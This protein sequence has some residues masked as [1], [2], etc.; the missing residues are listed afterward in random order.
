M[1][2]GRRLACEV[3]I[4]PAAPDRQYLTEHR[5]WPGLLVLRNTGICQRDSLAKTRTV[6]LKISRS[7]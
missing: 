4:Q 3:I 2:M 7:M 6:F 1:R 5:Y